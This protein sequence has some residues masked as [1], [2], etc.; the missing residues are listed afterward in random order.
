MPVGWHPTRCWNWCLTENEKKEIDQF[1][2][3]KLASVNS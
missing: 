2:L 1:L 3:I